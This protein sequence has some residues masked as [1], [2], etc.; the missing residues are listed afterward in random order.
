MDQDMKSAGVNPGVAPGSSV[1][2][3]LEQREIEALHVALAA[4]VAQ[5]LEITG[6]R[7]FVLVPHLLRKILASTVAVTAASTRCQRHS[8]RIVRLAARTNARC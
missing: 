8:P 7:H 1:D 5:R 6:V 2:L 3:G 4:G